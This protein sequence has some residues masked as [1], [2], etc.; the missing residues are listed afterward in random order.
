MLRIILCFK[1]CSHYQ[2]V[3]LQV[4]Q[5]GIYQPDEPYTQMQPSI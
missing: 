2:L 4:A 1:N 5:D 3:K